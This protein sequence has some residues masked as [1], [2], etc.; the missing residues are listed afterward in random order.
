MHFITGG[1]AA[2]GAEIEALVRTFVADWP[3]PIPGDEHGDVEYALTRQEWEA[4]R[5]G[6]G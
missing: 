4:Q 6:A 2:P 3:G 1:R 5:S